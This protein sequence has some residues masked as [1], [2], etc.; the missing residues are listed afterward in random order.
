M[1]GLGA[2]NNLDSSSA[3]WDEFID[4]CDTLKNEEITPIAFG[5]SDKWYTMWYVGQF[6]ANFVNKDVR[7][8]DYNPSSGCV[9]PMKDM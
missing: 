2:D 9:L 5:N 4:V 6:N 7:T 8:A 3:T 1:A